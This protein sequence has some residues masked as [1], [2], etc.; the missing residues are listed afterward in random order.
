MILKKI[1]HPIY[2]V[3]S[4]FR[5]EYNK[6][7]GKITSISLLTPILERAGISLEKITDKISGKNIIDAILYTGL[8]HQGKEKDHLLQNDIIK[9]LKSIDL[10]MY[11]F[12]I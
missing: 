12:I 10:E 3:F 7:L 6:L 1:H 2:K 9:E 4:S 11:C 5:I 8:I